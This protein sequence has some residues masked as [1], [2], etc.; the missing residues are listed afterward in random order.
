MGRRYP[1]VGGQ[2]S[3]TRFDFFFLFGHYPTDWRRLLKIKHQEESQFKLL[4]Y[5]S[6]HIFCTTPLRSLLLKVCCQKLP[7]PNR[8][9]IKTFCAKTKKPKSQLFLNNQ[10]PTHSYHRNYLP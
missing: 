3:T 1:N 5:N 4:L 7:K 8:Q 10:K 2:T 9:A 6:V